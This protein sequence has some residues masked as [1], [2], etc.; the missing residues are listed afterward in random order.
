M[1]T[2]RAET[3]NE[4]ALGDPARGPARPEILTVDFYEEADALV[5]HKKRGGGP[6]P[7]LLL[8]LIGWTVGCVFL[9]VAAIEDPTLGNLAFVLPFWASWLLVA[10]LIVWMLFGKETFFLSREEAILRRTALIRL[11]L[12]VVPR[13][14]VR[15]FREC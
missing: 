6:W 2:N 8:W 5:V 14:E 11:S 12:R 3:M 9:L 1:T 13:A 10:C 7:F 4:S 15:T